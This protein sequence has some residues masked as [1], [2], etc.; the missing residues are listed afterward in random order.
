MDFTNQPR[1]TQTHITDQPAPQPLH[2]AALPPRSVRT[3]TDVLGYLLLVLGVGVL[4]VV[5]ALVGGWP[6]VSIAAFVTGLGA[7]H[8]WTWGRSFSRKVAG[9]QAADFRRQLNVDPNTLS[10]TERP[11]HY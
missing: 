2:P 1:P 3:R 4:T 6:L 5:M 7:I 8:Y 9:E 11:R 10:E